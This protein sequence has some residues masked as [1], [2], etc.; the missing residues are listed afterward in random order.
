MFFGFLVPFFDVLVG[1]SLVFAV[2]GFL[3]LGFFGF[4]FGVFGFFFFWS[5]CFLVLFFGLVWKV[6]VGFLGSCSLFFF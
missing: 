2:F 6:F 4:W 5:F 1:E 3:V